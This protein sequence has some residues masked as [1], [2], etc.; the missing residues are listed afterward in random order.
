[1][2][3]EFLGR[4][5]VLPAENHTASE[6]KKKMRLNLLLESIGSNRQLLGTP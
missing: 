2:L 4:L 6:A 1:M 3:V 5:A